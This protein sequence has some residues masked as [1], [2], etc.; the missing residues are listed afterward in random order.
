MSAF[1]VV[2]NLTTP[3]LHHTCQHIRELRATH[4]LL[5]KYLGVVATDMLHNLQRLACVGIHQLSLRLLGYLLAVVEDNIGCVREVLGY[6]ELPARSLKKVF[7]GLLLGFREL[8]PRSQQ[9]GVDT[10]RG[11]ARR[12]EI[13]ISRLGHQRKLTRHNGHNG[14]QRHHIGVVADACAGCMQ[15]V[16]EYITTQILAQYLKKHLLAARKEVLA[17]ARTSVVIF[18]VGN[19]FL[20]ICPA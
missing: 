18:V 8:L 6:L 2:H 17:Y 19:I 3:A 7:A 5:W 15:G 20:V 4:A 11:D 10:E 1:W 9:L 12:G 14:L 16:I 13:L